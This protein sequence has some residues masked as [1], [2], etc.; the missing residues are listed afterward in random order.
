MK[1]VMI[2]GAVIV[3]LL[4]II[5]LGT[6]GS[7]GSSDGAEATDTADYAVDTTAVDTTAADM[8]TTAFGDCEYVGKTD[9]DGLP[10]GHGAAYFSDGSYYLGPFKHGEISGKDAY[11]K[12][13]DGD[14][15]EGEFRDNNYYYG[16]YT[17]A[18]DRSY[19]EGYYKDGQP[20]KG[21]WYDKNGNII[22]EI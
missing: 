3:L 11:Y 22:G 21:K 15:F 9:S 1:W 2:G 13:E 17:I 5:L 8:V 20:A 18:S 4:A 19:F 6:K 14:T 10:N 7:G 16:R 12:R